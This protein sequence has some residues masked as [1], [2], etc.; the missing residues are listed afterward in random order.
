MVTLRAL[1][2]LDPAFLSAAFTPPVPVC[3]PPPSPS[4]LHGH[5]LLGHVV[6]YRE[7]IIVGRS[8]GDPAPPARAMG[9]VTALA[10]RGTEKK[11]MKN[12]V[13]ND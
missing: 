11:T 9:Q 1:T 13:Q 7:S 8:V 2:P 3:F 6:P 5:H 12:L 4:L 10:T